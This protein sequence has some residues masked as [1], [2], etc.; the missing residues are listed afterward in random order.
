MNSDD[1]PKTDHDGFR[2][3]LQHPPEFTFQDED[4]SNRPPYARPPLEEFGEVKWQA[5]CQCGEVKYKLRRE[6]PLNAKFCHCRGCQ[7]M[8]GAPFQWAAIFPKDDI[9]FDNGTTGLSFYAAQERNTKYQTPTKVSCATCRTPIMDEGRNMCLLF[10]QLI[11]FSHSA[12]EQ[13]ER[14][15]TFLP[16]CHIF[17]EKRLRDIHD[18]IKKWKGMD[19]QSEILD[20]YGNPLKE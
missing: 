11:D 5:Q 15:A 14:I 17:Y 10:P 20:D 8:H 2:P 13:R 12:D 3:A 1:I 7:V 6:K 9:R 18:G 16:S 19:E 4:P